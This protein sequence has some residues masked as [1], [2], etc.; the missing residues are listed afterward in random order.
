M[1]RTWNSHFFRGQRDGGKDI[2]KTDSSQKGEGGHPDGRKSPESRIGCGTEHAAFGDLKTT[3]CYQST[4][5]E[6][7]VDE[8]EGVG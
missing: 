1:L 7:F 5:Y 6:E 4:Q 2:F 3:S 8:A